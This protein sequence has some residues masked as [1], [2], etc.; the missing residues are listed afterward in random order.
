MFFVRCLGLAL[1]AAVAVAAGGRCTPVAAQQK[2]DAPL[3]YDQRRLPDMEVERRNQEVIK[4]QRSIAEDRRREA[5][6]L[7]RKQAEDASRRAEEARIADEEKRITAVAAA[8]AES[9]RK[10]EEAQR[11]ATEVKSKADEAQRLAAET[12]AK[13][14]AD[15]EKQAAAE[16]EG[17]RKADE[18][19]RVAV[20]AEAKRKADEE[21][22]V[23]AE[24]DAKRRGDEEKRIAAEAEIIRKADEEKRVAAAAEAKRKA[25]EEKRVAAAAVAQKAPAQPAALAPAATNA[26]NPGPAATGA[27]CEAA[28]VSSSALAGGKLLI[29][30]DSACRPA[31]PVTIQYGGYDIVRRIGPS[32]QA[33]LVLDLFLG[34]GGT[35][36]V[37]FADGSSQVVD[38]SAGDLNG[39]SKVALIWQS[40][41]DLDLH[42]IEGGGGFGK[43]GHRW[44]GA[45]STMDAAKAESTDSGHGAGFLSTV[46]DGAH[47][48]TKV[49][50]Y[51]FV[52]SA[53]QE[54]GAV[55]ML[56]DYAS[57][58]AKPAGELCGT[59]ALAEIPFE[60]VI[61]DRKGRTARESGVIPAAKCGETLAGA[62]RYLKDAA[63]DLRFR[64]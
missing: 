43:Q 64:N 50:V 45:A 5:E 25:D 54:T 44:T 34:K 26:I 35:A 61:F 30:I 3:F 2:N 51:T 57:R 9:K 1:T 24:A 17:K 27:G 18:E 31:Q 39:L 8:E 49:E 29:S 32:G 6:A 22:R 16:A 38:A 33:N 62:A 7:T 36:K 59:G 19:K 12:D 37:T 53:D 42:A 63:P 4:E 58:G 48:G 55:S 20:E 11:F 41:V 28:K 40:A 47:E 10:A 52:H 56:V 21:K 15:E 14:R 60:V 46:D 23:A 13:R